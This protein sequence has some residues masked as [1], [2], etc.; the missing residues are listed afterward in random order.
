MIT[1]GMAATSPVAVASK[2]SAMP[3]AT[4]ARF[5]VWDFEIPMKLFMMPQTVPNR[6]TKGDIEPIVARNPMPCRT[7]RLPP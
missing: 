4:T 3:G 5:V 7:A 6:P 2:A 1:A